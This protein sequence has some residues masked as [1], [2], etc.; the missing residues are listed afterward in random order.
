MISADVEPA[1]AD[2]TWVVGE[3]LSMS[4]SCPTQGTTSLREFPPPQIRVWG[5]K[6][7]SHEVSL[8]I[9]GATMSLADIRITVRRVNGT[10][11]VMIDTAAQTVDGGA[12]VSLEATASDPDSDPLTYS[13]SGSGS[14]EDEESLD[15]KW[16]APAAQSS[17]R[18]YTLTVT[19]SD[20]SLSATDS[21]SMT[22]RRANRRPTV[23]IDTAAQTVDGGASVSLEATASD[24]DGD[25]LDY[26]WSG[27]GSFEDE[28]SL[29]TKWTAPA[30]QSSD[31]RYT[32]T[33]TVSDGS[34][35][36]TDSVSITVSAGTARRPSR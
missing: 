11:T 4:S 2:T 1:D 35:T 21:V 16:T 33:V 24:P 20:G 22:V 36:A 23:M 29:D 28:E 12:S 30:A 27:S 31:R 25:P 10:P 32:L 8:K 19:V 14:F 17:D 7:G 9:R 34:L 5:C 6:T 18:R 13:W 26:S 3:G 15:T